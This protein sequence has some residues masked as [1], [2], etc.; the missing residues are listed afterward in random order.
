[1][2]NSIRN[3]VNANATTN[4]AGIIGLVFS[5]RFA[6]REARK[7]RLMYWRVERS[8]NVQWPVAEAAEAMH[9]FRRDDDAGWRMKDLRLSADL[10]GD[11]TVED[12]DLFFVGMPMSGHSDATRLKDLLSDA[13]LLSA[14]DLP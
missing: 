5:D 14:V 10:N 7:K 8:Q 4:A 11:H 1:M 2:L 3:G 6:F 13:N 9:R 12:Q